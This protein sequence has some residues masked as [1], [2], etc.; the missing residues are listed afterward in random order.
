MTVYLVGVDGSETAKRAATR[1]GEL[2]KATGGTIH[3][4]CA[5][6]GRQGIDINVGSDSYTVSGLSAA[7]QIAEQQSAA[8]R[9]A[10][11]ASTS[12][13]GEGKPAEVLLDEAAKVHADVIVVGNKRMQGVARVLGAVANDVVHH[14]PCDV[15][16]VKTV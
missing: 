14:A 11:V 10:G 8:F 7:E 3:V 13:V 1:A 2:A 15:L 6:S 16:L 9:A 4:V 12:A 5:F